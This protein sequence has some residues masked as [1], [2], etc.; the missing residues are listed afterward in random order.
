[1]TSPESDIRRLAALDEPTRAALYRFVVEARGEVT[2]DQAGAALGIAR[3]RAAFHLDR[4]VA[5][6]LLEVDFRRLGDKSGPGAGRTSKLYRRS[7]ASFVAAVP[8]RHYQLAG[9]MLSEALTNVDRGAASAAITHAAAKR[10]RECGVAY[11]K[12]SPAERVTAMLEDLGFEPET[13][14]DGGMVL[15]NCPFHALAGEFPEQICGMNKAFLDAAVGAIG[16]D[17]YDTR[18]TR[19]EGRCC[20]SLSKRP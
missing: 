19:H 18:F 15:H 6:G 9:E 1:M 4:L 17:L 7:A 5:A 8:P 20:V 12:G 13:S 3:E 16:A 11:H 2:R 14:S 10:G